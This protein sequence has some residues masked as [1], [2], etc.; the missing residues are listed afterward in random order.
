[1]TKLFV[2]ALVLLVAYASASPSQGVKDMGADMVADKVVDT[3]ADSV[4]AK[5]V[6][7]GDKDNKDKEVTVVDKDNQDKEVTVVDKVGTALTEVIRAATSNTWRIYREIRETPFEICVESDGHFSTT[8][9]VSWS[10]VQPH[11]EVLVA[12]EVL[13]F[14]A[15][16]V[17]LPIRDPSDQVEQEA[18]DT[19][20]MGSLEELV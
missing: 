1:M 3:A 10:F 9:C 14:L 2:I 13:S 7:V 15:L 6:T 12:M 17:W 18:L 20:G 8:R 19:A 11:Q 4:V 16:L 5:E